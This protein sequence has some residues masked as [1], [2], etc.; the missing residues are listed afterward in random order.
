MQIC[1]RL[2]W[3]DPLNLVFQNWFIVNT[4][5]DY[6]F[7]SSVVRISHSISRF[8]QRLKI[9]YYRKCMT[10]STDVTYHANQ[11]WRN[12]IH[13]LCAGNPRW[14]KIVLHWTVIWWLSQKFDLGTAP[15]A[16][17]PAMIRWPN[18]Q[19][20]LYLRPC[21][22]IVVWVRISNIVLEFGSRS[23]ILPG[24]GFTI[25]IWAQNHLQMMENSQDIITVWQ[26]TMTSL[27]LWTKVVIGGSC[28]L[29]RVFF[30]VDGSRRFL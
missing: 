14:G 17:L 30:R 2:V 16:K 24:F 8:M 10:V 28:K 23:I 12:R 5:V 26:E 25:T 13:L 19:I 3:L 11:L 7:W 21:V 15:D 1:K 27:C 29:S 6:F 18:Q 9:M 20:T 4:K 22:W